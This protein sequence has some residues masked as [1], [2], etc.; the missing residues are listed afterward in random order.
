MSDDDFIEWMGQAFGI[1]FSE[2]ERK[3]ILKVRH[4]HDKRD[5]DRVVVA[6]ALGEN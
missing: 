4:E 6:L 1:K 5:V 2:E 3:S